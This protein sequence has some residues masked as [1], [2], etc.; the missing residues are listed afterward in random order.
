[1]VNVSKLKKVDHPQEIEKKHKDKKKTY[2]DIKL[3]KEIRKL[4]KEVKTMIKLLDE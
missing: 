1:M 3:V 4:R 2:K